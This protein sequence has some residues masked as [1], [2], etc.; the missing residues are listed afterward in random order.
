MLSERV[1]ALDAIEAEHAVV[2]RQLRDEH[3][4]TV[5]RLLETLEAKKEEEERGELMERESMPKA[6]QKSLLFTPK[7]G[8]RRPM[9][10]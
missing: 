5:E 3:E 8:L 2:C 6:C 7:T 9:V 4:A 1:R 10:D